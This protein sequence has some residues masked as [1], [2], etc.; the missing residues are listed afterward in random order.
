MF[1]EVNAVVRAA[2]RRHFSRPS[3]GEAAREAQRL[4]ERYQER[5]YCEARERAAGRCLD[6]DPHPRFWTRVKLEVARRQEIAI[7][8]SGAD[9]RA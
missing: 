6:G 7:G 4:I 3:G 2:A 8:L 1:Q 9:L 5:A